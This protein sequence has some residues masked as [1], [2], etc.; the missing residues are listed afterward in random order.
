MKKHF[1]TFGRVSQGWGSSGWAIGLTALSFEIKTEV[2]FIPNEA[3]PGKSTPDVRSKVSVKRASAAP[4]GT[5]GSERASQSD[6]SEK[7]SP[8]SPESKQ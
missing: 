6:E 7:D 2:R 3:R 8:P 1:K 5:E 4:P